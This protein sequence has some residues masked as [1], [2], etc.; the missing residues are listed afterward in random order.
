MDLDIDVNKYKTTD[1]Y[2]AAVLVANEEALVKV[3]KKKNSICTFLFELPQS[4]AEDI[5]SKH[6][7]GSLNLP[8]KNVI[9]AIRQVKNRIFQGA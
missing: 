6:W 7:N 4:T 5:I 2:L 8:T 1:M 3:I 9:A